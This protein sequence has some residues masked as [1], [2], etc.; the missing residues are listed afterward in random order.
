M[1]TTGSDRYRRYK[2]NVIDKELSAIGEPHSQ[3][4]CVSAL[5]AAPA[6]VNDEV[7]DLEEAV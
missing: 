7:L 1:S 5:T 4:I 2:A 6:G 3:Q